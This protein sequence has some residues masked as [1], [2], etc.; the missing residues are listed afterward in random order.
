MT[1]EVARANLEER[2]AANPYPGRGIVLG[3][4]DRGLWIQVYWIMGRSE[5]SRNR[6]FVCEGD[7]VRTQ[8][9]DASKVEDPSLIIY[10]AMR[11]LDSV[12]IATNG[13]QTDGL[14]E[15]MAQGKSFTESLEG[16]EHEPDAPNFT[17]RISTVLDLAGGAAWFSVIKASPFAPDASEHHFHR[18]IRIDPG[19]GYTV[20]TYTGDGKP[21]PSFAGP[22]YLTPLEGD[23]ASIAERYWQALDSDNR[24]ALAVR[25]IDP[26]SSEHQTQVI[27]KYEAQSR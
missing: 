15:G 9:A 12:Y 20:T 19:C 14:Y 5:H 23:A 3:R 27:N 4:S 17:P 18:Y 6:I 2:L 16:W 26:D 25:E 22:P 24:I 11:R 21:L 8:A 13:A 7:T 10:N 1:N